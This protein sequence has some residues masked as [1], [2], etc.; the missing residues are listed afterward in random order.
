VKH[1][2]KTQAP[3]VAERDA[4]C[5]ADV[6]RQSAQLAAENVGYVFAG[7]G[8]AADGDGIGVVTFCGGLVRGELGQPLGQVAMVAGRSA[9]IPDPRQK[10]SVAWSNAIELGS[11]DLGDQDRQREGVTTDLLPGCFAVTEIELINGPEQSRANREPS[12]FPWA[13]CHYLAGLSPAMV[14]LPIVAV[15]IQGRRQPTRRAWE[16]PGLPAISGAG[17]DRAACGACDSTGC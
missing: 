13:R 2:A 14:C 16:A 12:C 11:D 17:T 7:V 6:L 5:L 4:C 1:D 3:E 8:A 9:V 10:P 15:G